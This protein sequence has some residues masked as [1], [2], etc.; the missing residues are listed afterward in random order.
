MDFD[1]DAVR[2][3]RERMLLRMLFRATHTFNAEMTRR[4]RARGWDAFQPSFTTLLGHIDTEGTTISTLAA[5]T[6]TSRQAVSQLAP[7]IERAGL[8]ERVANPEDGRS[9]VVRHTAAGR[10][11]LLD[12]IEVMEEI[13]AEYAAGIGV[14][15][16]AELKR[17]LSV[18][19]AEI[20][21][22][23]TLGPPEA[24]SSQ[25]ARAGSGRSGRRAARTNRE[26][27]GPRH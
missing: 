17:L 20:D 3:R 26:S 13:E 10:R 24:S 22:A 4:V 25:A 2:A 14:R 21:P 5:R 7:A 16:L 6:G 9:V 8:V 11:I 23:G 27:R 18:L 19:L 12:A 1:P 15:R